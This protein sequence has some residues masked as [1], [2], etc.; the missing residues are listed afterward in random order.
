MSE[1]TV[2]AA[3]R[4]SPCSWGL[5]MRDHRLG[6]RALSVPAH[7][8]GAQGVSLANRARTAGPERPAPG[9]W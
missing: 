2:E 9:V 6:L 8:S 3:L 4:A 1:L 5:V 7:K